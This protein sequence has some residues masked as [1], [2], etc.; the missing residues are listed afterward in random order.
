[1]SIT[2]DFNLLTEDWGA[3]DTIISLTLPPT[4]LIWNELKVKAQQ[5]GE[6][7]KTYIQNSDGE[8]VVMCFVE[9]EHHYNIQYGERDGEIIDEAQ[10]KQ[11]CGI[12][13]GQ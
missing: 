3:E 6:M 9:G 13:V 1:M 11:L 7:M 2:V 5:D 4:E 10:A 12:I 8:I